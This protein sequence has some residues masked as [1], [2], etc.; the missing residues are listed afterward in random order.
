MKEPKPIA[1][2]H[3]DEESALRTILEGTSAETGEPFFAA[4]V[5]NLAKALDTTAAWVTELSEDC[6][7]LRA[8]A[9]WF[10]GKWVDDYEYTVLG[11][12]CEAVVGEARLVHVPDKAVELYPNDSDFK[13][14][15]TVSYM[16]VPLTDV[17][18]RV[19]GHLAVMHAEPLPEEPRGVAILQIFAARASAELRRLRAESELLW[20]EQKL[21][22]LVDGAMDAIIELDQNLKVTRMNPAAEKVLGCDAG[23]VEGKDF[24]RFVSAES[25]GKLD[26]LISELDS[27]PPDARYLWIPSGLDAKRADGKAFPAEATLSRFEIRGRTFHTLILRNIDERKEAEHKI[28]SLTVE[29]EYLREQI[30]A[31]QD[32]GE[33]IG[34]SEPM[35]RLLGDIREVAETDATVLLHGETGTGK[36]VVARTIHAASRRS[37]KPLINVN[38]AAIPATLMES[39]FFGHEKGAFTGATQKREGRFALADGG[40]IFLDEVGE[41]PLELQSKLLRVLQEGEFEPVGSSKTQRVD[42]R[43]LAATNRNLEESV[44]KGSFRKD[45]FYRLDV[46]PMRLPPLRDRGDDIALLATTFAE[47]S[48]RR[49]GRRIELSGDCIRRLKAYSWPGNVRELENVIERAVITSRDHR[50]NL[51]RALPATPANDAEAAPLAPEEPSQHDGAILTAQALQELERQNI[52]RAL[53]RAGWRVAGDGGAA[54]LLGMKPSTLSSRIKALG[55]KRKALT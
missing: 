27:L 10:D 32:S 2:P 55:I 46:F 31:L 19:L 38:C 41:L 26:T 24:A 42:V 50:L 51:D 33:I 7:R 17:D 45:L 1:T 3:L 8:L 13:K 18:G 39:E 52:L 44:Q 6:Q 25:K 40:T 5:K 47:L 21:S 22:R 28:R 11:T 9:F 36:E 30:K 4:L 34:E 48:A 23:D 14:L 49:M 16:G 35:K 43:V 54:E 15:G 37:K 29:T 20:R 12:P 53:E